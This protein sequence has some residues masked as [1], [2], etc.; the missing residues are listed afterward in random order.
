MNK[1]I[2]TILFDFDGT[3]A[4]TNDLIIQ[5]WQAVYRARLGHE[6][7]PEEILATF[8]EPLYYT[9]GKVFPDFDIEE[10]VDIYR[11]FQKGIFRQAIKPFPGMV[12]LIK[13]LKEQGYKMGIV[14]SRLKQSTFE[15]LEC[16]GL[17]NDID[18]IVTVEDTDKH[19]PDPEPALICLERLGAKPEEAIMIGDSRFDIGCANNAGITSVLVAWSIAKEGQDSY[20]EPSHVI[21]KAEE[22]WALLE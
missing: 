15:G 6:G 13:G 8:G 17:E 16:F 7:K 4:D 9:M 21:E 2:N 20:Y 10:S 19:K 12:D 5:S 11:S 22:F 14:T 18:E 3:I 1:K